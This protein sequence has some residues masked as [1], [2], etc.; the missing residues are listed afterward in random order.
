MQ[1]WRRLKRI[2]AWFAPAVLGAL[3]VLCVLG[4]FLGAE[5]AAVF[6]NSAPLIVLWAAVAALLVVSLVVF[7]RL[8][9]S[10]ALLVLHVAPLLILAGGAWGSKAA[11]HLRARMSRFGKPESGYMVIYEGRS[12]SS[13]LD[14]DLRHEK[15]NLPFGLRLKDFRVEYYPPQD[16]RWNLVASVPS[17]ERGAG[18][19]H[20]NAARDGPQVVQNV[21]EWQ[22]GQEVTIPH[23][24]ARVEVLEYIQSARPEIPEGAKPRL[25]VRTGDGREKV[26]PAEAGQRVSLKKPAAQLE[27]VRVFS[28][29]KVM[30]AGAD[31]KV[32]DAEGQGSN[33]ALKVQVKPQDGEAH[34]VYLMPRYPMHGQVLEG[35]TLEYALPEP[36]GAAPDPDTEAPAMKV[37]VSRDGARLTEWL[38]VGE[39]ADHASVSLSPLWREEGQADE[40]AADSAWL[41]LARP[42]S[43]PRAYKSDLV[44]LEERKA[45]VEKTVQVN[46]PLH[47]GGFHIYQ[48]SYDRQGGR[49]TVLLVK[50]DSGLWLVYAGLFLLG[51]GSFWWCWV[52]PVRSF[53]KR[54]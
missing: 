32:V 31:R 37:R 42:A 15:A 13:L 9:R 36:R 19:A 6:F 34:H 43:M 45:V 1:H 4:A 24:D 38:I 11:H 40:A 17:Q 25:R 41:Y 26:V 27:V 44:V 30:G 46:D 8:R 39:G 29:L 7:R 48:S 18:S 2:I 23:T 16:G 47:Y 10:P 50:S 22:E 53:F 5:R 51:V 35:V 49:Y 14:E 33:P 28:N 21:L 52:G 3:A 54:E 12:S 20:E